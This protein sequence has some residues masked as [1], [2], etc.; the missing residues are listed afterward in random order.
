MSSRLTTLEV[1]QIFAQGVTGAVIGAV[2]YPLATLPL[3]RHLPGAF[4]NTYKAI[5]KVVSVGPNLKAVAY[6]TVPIAGVAIPPLLFAGSA[7]F[8]FV[9][10]AISAVWTDRDDEKKQGFFSRV[11]GSVSEDLETVDKTLVEDLLPRL[12]D[13]QPDP[14]PEGEKPFDISPFRAVKGVLCG[15]VLTLLEAPA[16]ALITLLRVPG[17]FFSLLEAIFRGVDSFATL[18]LALLMTFLAAGVLV[19]VPP[20]LALGTI[21]FGVGAGCVRGYSDGVRSAVAGVFSDLGNWN[22]ILSQIQS[23]R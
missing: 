19:L 8:G 20:V 23:G 12:R 18:V 13:Y 9:R 1:L 7:L 17:L 21:C 16:L 11:F 14:L 10:G 3:N 5:H 15:V 22:K 6:V 2:S 4:V